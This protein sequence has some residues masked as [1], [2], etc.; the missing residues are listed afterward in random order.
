LNP[1]VASQEISDIAVMYTVMSEEFPAVLKSAA[2]IAGESAP[3]RIVPSVRLSE[4]PL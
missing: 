4:A 3:P 2:A 1:N